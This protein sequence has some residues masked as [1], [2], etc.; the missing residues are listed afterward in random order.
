MHASVLNLGFY[1]EQSRPDRD[2]YVRVNYANIQSGMAHNFDK[3]DNTVVNTQ[4]TPYDYASVMHYESDAFSIN[5]LPTIE[6]LQSGV[7][8]GQRDNM[9]SIDI[10]EVRMFYNCSVGG[11]TFP[12]VPTTTS[13]TVSFIYKS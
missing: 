12:T 10:Q 13:G 7:T 8:V 5:G 2:S 3:Y 11:V 6:P 4:N 1:H 9:S